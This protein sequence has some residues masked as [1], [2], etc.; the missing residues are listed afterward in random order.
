MAENINTMGK[1]VITVGANVITAGRNGSTSSQVIPQFLWS[2]KKIDN[3]H[4]QSRHET[5][6]CPTWRHLGNTAE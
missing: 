1:I 5:Q 3:Y 6:K 2:H 4:Q